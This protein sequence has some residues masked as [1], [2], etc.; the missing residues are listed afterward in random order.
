[1]KISNVLGGFYQNQNIQQ[2]YYKT[3]KL[4]DIEENEQKPCPLEFPLNLRNKSSTLNKIM[5]RGYVYKLEFMY[6]QDFYTYI[7]NQEYERVI[8][9][10][11]DENNTINDYFLND[12]HS[13]FF[14]ITYN[15]NE[16]Y[17]HPKQRY[18]IYILGATKNIT[19]KNNHLSLYGVHSQIIKFN[20]R[21]HVQDNNQSIDL[22]NCFDSN[23]R[24]I[25]DFDKIGIKYINNL[26]GFCTGCNY[27]ETGLS[28][29]FNT[30]EY[31][32]VI[33][34]E[35]AF[36]KFGKSF[37]ENL[38]LQ[39]I[40]L[41]PQCEPGA[42]NGTF[43]EMVSKTNIT[44]QIRHFHYE[45]VTELVNTFNDLTILRDDDSYRKLDLSNLNFSNVQK[46]ERGFS[47]A[48]RK[49]EPQEVGFLEYGYDEIDL[50]NSIFSNLEELNYTSFRGE[51][52]LLN[53]VT[54]PKI[55]IYNKSAFYPH[56]IVYGFDFQTNVWSKYNQITKLDQCF[57]GDYTNIDMSN[58]VND[59]LTFYSRNNGIITEIFDD[60]TIDY[61]N[62]NNQTFNNINITETTVYSQYNHS[63]YLG[64]EYSGFLKDIFDKHLF[65]HAN[66]NTVDINNCIFSD[67][68]ITS[69]TVY[70]KDCKKEK[71][72]CYNIIDAL[73][74]D[75]IQIGNYNMNNCYF[76]E[77]MIPI[78]LCWE[79][80]NLNLTYP[81]S[82]LPGA[83]LTIMTLTDD[84]GNNSWRVWANRVFS[85]YGRKINLEGFIFP[86]DSLFAQTY[87]IA[88][89]S[90]QI[91]VTGFQNYYLEELNL[92][93][94]N[95]NGLCLHRKS[96]DTNGYLECDKLKK[97]NISYT[98]NYIEYKVN[99]GINYTYY[100]S[101]VKEIIMN[102]CTCKF[103]IDLKKFIDEHKKL[104]LEKIDISDITYHY[105]PTGKTFNLFDFYN[106]PSSKS[107]IEVKADNY[108][109]PN[110]IDSIFISGMNTTSIDFNTFLN[111]QLLN[112]T[113]K[114]NSI[115]V[116]DCDNLVSIKMLPSSLVE[117]KTTPYTY[118][119]F[120][121]SY[122]PKL[123]NFTFA[124]NDKIIIYYLNYINFYD[125]NSLTTNSLHNIFS[126]IFI[127]YPISNSGFLN[128]QRCS[129][130]TDVNLS[131]IETE[132]NTKFICNLK[133]A[134][135]G[136]SNLQSVN[137]SNINFDS[138][139]NLDNT[140]SGCSSLKTPPSLTFSYSPG[141]SFSYTFSGCSSLTSFINFNFINNT[142]I[143]SMDG[144]FS[145]CTSLTFL[146]FSNFD[147]SICTDFS[148]S[149]NGCTSLLYLDLSNLNTTNLKSLSGMFKECTSLTSLNLSNFNTSLC[150]SF[151]GL[152]Q[153]CTSLTT[154]DLSNFNT[155]KGKSF[156][157]MFE[158]CTSLIS[159]NLSNFNTENVTNFIRMFKGCTSLTSLNLSNFNTENAE[160][161]EGMFQ[162]CTSL[163]S[164]DLSSFETPKAQEMRRM[165]QDCTSLTTLDVSNFDVYNTGYIKDDDAPAP[166]Y[167]NGLTSMFKNCTSLINLNMFPI[168]IPHSEVEHYDHYYINL[169]DMFRDCSSLRELDLQG[170]YTFMTCTPK[171]IVY[172]TMLDHTFEGC[173]NLKTIYT[174]Q[175]D[176]TIIDDIDKRM[177]PHYKY[178]F[179]NCLSLE[180]GAGTKYATFHSDDAQWAQVD[181]ETRTGYFTYKSYE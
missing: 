52:L 138:I 105:N 69:T 145:G 152:F 64:K 156:S 71:F 176:T 53:N 27:L 88:L 144:M 133:S 49:K 119:Y 39:N 26:K 66:I 112:N 51:K 118:G 25:E 117:I 83:D 128:I 34:L 158:G 13:V 149:F 28:A 178:T 90:G 161:F 15:S 12:E 162:E 127:S 165:F 4:F 166:H 31:S 93:H 99:T 91:V 61:I 60:S 171:H 33:S 97:V 84:L 94:T 56:T 181:T 146:D 70:A 82:I 78:F 159:L 73:F 164:L 140:F 129:S 101:Y 96:F 104:H 5:G 89:S 179:T 86:L 59:L 6:Y 141:V 1:M 121:F 3:Y 16:G 151:S 55:K 125:C 103:E 131:L 35:G 21:L 126:H 29:L 47:I 7:K 75:S 180:G 168:N 63:E 41:S 14:Q 98:P 40:Q 150:S 110:E 139:D 114:I 38:N 111:G 113:I 50:S 58:C 160:R 57:C 2:I 32:E 62:L 106:Y 68:N 135:S 54:F 20:D 116:T 72:P 18:N 109:I 43:N 108:P 132:N 65:F 67:L 154:L 48:F 147:T 44:S 17:A 19:I 46:I 85:L 87:M 170:F 36:R 102:H 148:D 81:L 24:I 77:N 134:F 157:T 100:L 76:G 115:K 37:Q 123:T 95:I 169:E 30:I 172:G 137:L 174:D 74:R 92:S 153:E 177:E 45:Y 136:C 42:L 107:P 124:N 11:H 142:K 80:D 155:E 122:N 120:D 8:N 143:T 23:I 79:I 10:L 22:S 130:L 167:Y 175:M 173:T 163:V 9:V